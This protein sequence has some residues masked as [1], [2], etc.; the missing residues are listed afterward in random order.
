MTVLLSMQ[1]SSGITR[2]HRLHKVRAQGGVVASYADVQRSRTAPFLGPVADL[3]IWL[4]AMAIRD[5]N[6]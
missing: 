2:W 3:G 1:G 5:V 6:R 4:L